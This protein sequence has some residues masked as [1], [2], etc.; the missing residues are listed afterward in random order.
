[1]EADGFT[2]A[3]MVSYK[4]YR[5]STGEEFDLIV[6]YDLSMENSTG[7]YYS[8]SFAGITN[9]TTGITS[10]DE[11][12]ANDVRLYPNPAR[13][14]VTIDF[15]NGSNNVATVSF[16]DMHGRIVMEEIISAGNSEINVTNLKQGVYFVSIKS[17]N[18]NKTIK[19]VIK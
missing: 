18:F 17:A 12:G 19:L 9:M 13:D 15:A 14:V 2:E 7:L 11:M 4:L 3:E 8:N 1:L 5:T 10:I 16:F 6:E